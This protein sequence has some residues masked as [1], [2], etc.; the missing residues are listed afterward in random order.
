SGTDGCRVIP[1]IPS[2]TDLHWCLPALSPVVRFR[3][4]ALERSRLVGPLAFLQ[5]GRRGSDSTARHRPSEVR[6]VASLQPH[7]EGRSLSDK[8]S[9]RQRFG[10]WPRTRTQDSSTEKL[11][12]D[13]QRFHP[14]TPSPHSSSPSG[15]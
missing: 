13:A 2:A 14:D 3:V 8:P 6:T 10:P 7:Q 1:V 9:R 12:L 11:P 4:A 15:Q 5:G